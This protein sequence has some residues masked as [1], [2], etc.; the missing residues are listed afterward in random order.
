M[1]D[2]LCAVTFKDETLAEL[3]DPIQE[4]DVSSLKEDADAKPTQE[5]QEE[6]AAERARLTELDTIREFI[7]KKKAFE[8]ANPIIVAAANEARKIQKEEYK[9][10]KGN[11]KVAGRGRPRKSHVKEVTFTVVGKDTFKLPG[12]GRPGKA[13]RQKFTLHHSQAVR[14]DPSKTYSR[15]DINAMKAS[16]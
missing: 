7:T 2:I 8:A 10:K 11:K 12:R 14:L 4:L 6:E 1:S 3:L 16:L 5:E 13:A 9:K 15:A